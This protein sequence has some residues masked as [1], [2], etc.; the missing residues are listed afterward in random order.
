M[1]TYRTAGGIKVMEQSTDWLRTQVNPEELDFLTN[2]E[3]LRAARSFIERTQI[4]LTM[5]GPPMMILSKLVQDKE[6]EVLV[7]GECPRCFHPWTED[8]K[9]L[10]R[11]P[12]C[13]IIGV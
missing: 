7:V 4:P 8:E 1:K 9:V 2:G 3:T 12:N 13:L 10:G 11:C 5:I 6:R